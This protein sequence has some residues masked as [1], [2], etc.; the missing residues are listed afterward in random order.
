MHHIMSYP[1]WQVM[2]CISEMGFPYRALTFDG[3]CRVQSCSVPQGDG[4]PADIAGV[5]ESV[6]VS[7]NSEQDSR[8][9]EAVTAGGAGA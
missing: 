8:H 7:C 5:A 2:L 9:A 6:D 1:V 4:G 3:F